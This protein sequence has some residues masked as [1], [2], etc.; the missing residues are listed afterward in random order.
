LKTESWI[1]LFFSCIAVFL[2]TFSFY[3]EQTNVTEDESIVAERNVLAACQSALES[4][5]IAG[6]TL[7]G[8]KEVREQSIESFYK[9]Y[10]NNFNLVTQASKEDAKLHIP[11]IFLVDWDGYY[12][13]Y[14][15]TY[16]KDGLTYS[17]SNITPL[18]T[19]SEVYGSYIVNY[20]LD[21]TITVYK[22]DEKL[23]G[24]FDRVAE[25]IKEKYGA[26]PTELAFLLSEE[27]F[28][29]EKNIV[30]I[31]MLNEQIQYYVNLHN[32]HYNKYGTSYKIVLPTGEGGIEAGLMDLP[33]VIAFNQGKQ[34]GSQ[35][36]KGYA[37]VYTFVAADYNDA[38]IYY[39][40][41]EPDGSYTYH[42]K[43]CTELIDARIGGTQEECAKEGAYPGSCVY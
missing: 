10:A 6:E 18:N 16:K 17:E 25:K 40:N 31:S 2:I 20:R 43:G 5:D 13:S 33:C 34:M 1:I 30:V 4:S 29:N 14:L 39:L 22:N 35:S 27:E 21:N 38:Q 37:N 26:V 12:I 3:I 28:K 7:F 11:A 15:T 41:Q 8:Q 23:V 19:W 42:V 9:T 32:E 36:G 24:R